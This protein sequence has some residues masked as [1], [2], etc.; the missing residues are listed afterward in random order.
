MSDMM[1]RLRRVQDAPVD[2]KT[3]LVRVDYNVPLADGEVADDAR[4][5]ASLPTLN[6][7]LEHAAKPVLLTHLGRPEG[8]V[9]PSLRLDHV[10]AHLQTLLGHPVHKLDDCVG[11]EVKE[12]IE[13]GEE[14]SVFLLENVR[15]HP[16]EVADE[17]SF[18][19]RLAEL[20][21]LYIND[22]F[23]TLH[24]A[25]ASTLGICDYLPSYAGL[26]VQR[27]IEAL[28]HLTDNPARPYL[29]IIGG[30]KAR[31][32]LGTL[33]DFLDR[34]NAILIGGG[35]AFTFLRAQGIQVGD[36]L[37]DESLLG[38]ITKLIDAAAEKEVAIHL[39]RDVVVATELSAE[40]QTKV[41]STTDIPSRWMGLDIGPETISEFR[42]QIAIAKTIVWAGPMGAFEIEPFSHGTEEIAAALAGADAFTVV[43]GGETGEAVAKSGHAEE[44]SYIS[45]GGGACLALLR[46]KSLPAL[47]VLLA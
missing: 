10:A 25:H 5:K 9:V 14:G 33:R 43:G 8:K 11:E 44:I 17:A 7:L 4:I 24:R 32:K 26:L 12:A 38:E 30:K 13:Q 45:T 16:E 29:A 42:D 46:G 20:G 27:E 34:V 22:A 18:A 23:A 47:Q 39:P 1:D 31:S 28:S 37:V 36:S 21:D 19:R 41:C 35:V 2:G 3:V 6:Y 15:F 40:A